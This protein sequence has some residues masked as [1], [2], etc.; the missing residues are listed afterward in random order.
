MFG[1]VLPKTTTTSIASGTPTTISRN[2]VA[3]ASGA[4][5]V[6]NLTVTESAV[7]NGI[8]TVSLNDYLSATSF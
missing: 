8:G 1:E 7:P 2:A 6:N 4:V 5:T 3:I